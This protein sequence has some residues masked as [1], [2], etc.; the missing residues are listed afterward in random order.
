MGNSNQNKHNRS[1][2]KTKVSFLEMTL[3]GFFIQALGLCIEAVQEFFSVLPS[4]LLRPIKNIYSP[5]M[6][7]RGQVS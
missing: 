4:N 5:T 7:F 3:E 1:C 6:I 2:E